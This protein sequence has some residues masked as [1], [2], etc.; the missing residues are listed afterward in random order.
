MEYDKKYRRSCCSGGSGGGGTAPTNGRKIQFIHPMTMNRPPS[1]FSV[2]LS[3]SLWSTLAYNPGVH[4]CALGIQGGKLACT[5][6]ADPADEV[7]S[8]CYV[9]AAQGQRCVSV[10]FSVG[11]FP[12]FFPLSGKTTATPGDHRTPFPL[13]LTPSNLAFPIFSGKHDPFHHHRWACLCNAVCQF[14]IL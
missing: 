14:C 1:F 4:G 2:I 10:I 12:T 5:K 9:K 3:W 13:V 6:A 8:E 11:L 7:P